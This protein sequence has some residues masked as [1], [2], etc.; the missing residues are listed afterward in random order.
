MM[1]ALGLGKGSRRVSHPRFSRSRSEHGEAH[2]PPGRCRVVPACRPPRPPARLSMGAHDVRRPKAAR[3]PSGG[4]GSGC[5]RRAGGQRAA[6]RAA[7]PASGGGGSRR[8]SSSCIKRKRGAPG[9]QC[10]HPPS[11]TSQE[12]LGSGE[13]AAALRLPLDPEGPLF[14]P[15]FFSPSPLLP[16]SFPPCIIPGSLRWSVPLP[17]LASSAPGAVG[18]RLPPPLLLLFPACNLPFL[19]RRA[20]PPP[21]SPPQPLPLLGSLI[22]WAGRERG[23]GRGAFPCDPPLPS[24]DVERIEDPWKGR[25]KEETQEEK[26]AVIAASLLWTV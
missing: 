1:A 6:G 13:G 15:P 5:A 3:A 12:G 14:S 25:V 21:L 26:K 24:V 9:L 20:E 11:R 17:C 10:V 23:G 19:P 22:S 2:A 18:C 7:F 4:G 16:A 8:W